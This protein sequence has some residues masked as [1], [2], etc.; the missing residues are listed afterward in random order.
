MAEKKGTEKRVKP[1][2]DAAD[3]DKIAG[4]IVSLAGLALDVEGSPEAE[5][6]ARAV[7]SA[8]SKAWYARRGRDI[9]LLLRFARGV[10]VEVIGLLDQRS[11]K[12]TTN[13]V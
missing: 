11:K 1:G 9:S 3:L 6:N 8:M 4:L 2:K 13:A 7:T 5:P 10:E 12:V